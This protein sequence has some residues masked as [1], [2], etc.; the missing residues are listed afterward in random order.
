[1]ERIP[2]LI[3]DEH[4]QVRTQILARLNR[5]PD[6]DIVAL[7]DNSTDAIN[8]ANETH[9]RLILMDPMMSDGL[10][11]DAIRR[12]HIELPDSVVVILAA[13]V[14]TAQTIALKEMGVRFILNKGIESYKL[15]QVLH[16]AADC[17]SGTYS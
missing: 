10:G 8:L 17:T 15:V 11:L 2:I 1:M 14:D 13:F 12:L 5:E 6:F 7:A 3:A 4:I 9:P 16:Q